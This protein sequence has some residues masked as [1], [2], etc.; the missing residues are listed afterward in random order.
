MSRKEPD[1]PPVE[2]LRDLDRLLEQF[3]SA[4]LRLDVQKLDETGALPAALDISAYRIV[5]E[6][7]TNV[8]RHGGPIAQLSIRRSGGGIRRSGGGA[9]D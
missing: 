7:L 9:L 6:G 4:G 2:G 1:R 8:L 3:R 5:Q